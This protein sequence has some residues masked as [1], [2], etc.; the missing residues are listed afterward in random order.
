ME[1]YFSPHRSYILSD[2]MPRRINP[3]LFFSI[4]CPTYLCQTHNRQQTDEKYEP[5]RK[6]KTKWRSIGRY[7]KPRQK[8]GKGRTISVSVVLFRAPRGIV[9]SVRENCRFDNPPRKVTRGRI[10]GESVEE[11]KQERK[12]RLSVFFDVCPRR[13]GRSNDAGWELAPDSG[14]ATRRG[15]GWGEGWGWK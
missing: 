14:E 10:G 3:F 6:R 9:G 13:D 4:L 2:R 5:E 11:R 15:K 1:S 12:E 7:V 8:R